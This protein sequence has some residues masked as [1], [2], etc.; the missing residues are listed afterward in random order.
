MPKCSLRPLSLPLV[1]SVLVSL[2]S[3]QAGT[4]RFATGLA[5]PTYLTAPS[6][7]PTRV[8]VT[9]LGGDIE[10]LDVATGQRAASP[11]LSIA[12]ADRLAAMAFDPGYA[13]N[14][15]F[16][17]Y[18]RDAAG[19]AR[20]VRYEASVSDRELADPASAM[21]VLQIAAAGHFGGWIGFGPDGYLYVQVGDG[22]DFMSHDA[23]GNGQ[24]TTAE[25][26]ANVLRIDV[27]GDDFP[28]DAD[29]NYAIPPD[30]PF[31]GM[32][33]RD[34][35]WAFGLR[36]PWRGSFDRLTGDYY[37]ADVGQ[38]AR[39][40]IDVEPAGSSGGRNYGWRLREGRIA[41]PTGGV[42]GPRPA[43]AVDPVYDYQHGFGADQG[44][45][46]TGGYVYRGSI[47]ALQGRYFFADYVNPRIWSLRV[48][49]Q[50]ATVT[51]F[52]DWTHEFAPTIGSLDNIVSFGEDA[53]GELYIVDYDGDIFRVIATPTTASNTLLG[54][55]CHGPAL[56][57]A[58]RPVLGSDWDLQLTNLPAGSLL[59]LA[60]VGFA[61]PALALDSLG[62]PGCVLHNDLQAIY[63]VPV[64]VANPAYRLTLPLDP[65]LVGARFYVQ[66]AVFHAAFNT[67]GIITSNGVLG[68]AGDI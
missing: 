60:M 29:R 64:P 56:S 45:S 13:S 42:G 68:T 25:L 30:N 59:A 67:L 39:E 55:G 49:A 47:A 33:G 3:A 24:G 2:A 52:V 9:E 31:V 6:N 38:D 36:N 5:Q 21:P 44:K 11:F 54:S 22:G 35:I 8:F 63:T 17:V 4:V 27:D 62:A 65:A 40:E 19:T 53:V 28:A 15:R 48:D 18:Y 46:V 41:T 34:E 10:L 58:T 14:R 1:A 51:E 23:P 50:A 26:L 20:L 43:G 37:L 61:D 7:D 32:A 16:Y 66:G 12:N 57:G